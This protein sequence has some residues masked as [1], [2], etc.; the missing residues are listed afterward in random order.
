MT[1]PNAVTVDLDLF[2]GLP[3]TN[4]LTG[5][6]ITNPTGIS[7]QGNV[8][9]VTPDM[10]LPVGKPT[11][12][13]VAGDRPA[14]L[15][16]K[17]K[18]PEALAEAYR[19]LETRLGAGGLPAATPAAAPAA[20]PVAATAAPAAPGAPAAAATPAAAP[21]AATGV[22]EAA[23]AEAASGSLKPETVESL[24]KA[25]VPKAVVEG[26]LSQATFAKQ[27]AEHAIYNEF[28]GPAGYKAFAEQAAGVLSPADKAV[29]NSMLAS[30]NFQQMIAGV[31]LA[32][33][34]V[35][36]ASTGGMLPVQAG[37]FTAPEAFRS[38][39]ELQRAIEDPRYGQ[40]DAYMEEFNRKAEGWLRLSTRRR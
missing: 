31:Q 17:F 13:P 19:A 16:E 3:E 21:D 33:L 38:Q 37:A 8:V 10:G 15:P 25:G 26:V 34:K 22:W 14:W 35:A 32:R 18:S 4:P 7:R 6:T 12:P 24:T 40:D 5:E 30:G 29:V 36:Q 20:A 2:G 28:G 39:A 27:A 23:L 11:A 1:Q 9:S